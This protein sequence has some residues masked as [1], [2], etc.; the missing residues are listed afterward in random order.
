MKSE[1]ILKDKKQIYSFFSQCE[2]K[3][4]VHGRNPGF[5]E[6][7]GPRPGFHENPEN[8]ENRVNE[9]PF[10]KNYMGGLRMVF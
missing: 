8:W 10:L 1:V 3:V 5:G 6:T 4:E 9:N 2:L 7:D